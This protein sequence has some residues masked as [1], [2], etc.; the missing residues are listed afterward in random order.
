MIRPQM[1]SGGID[2]PSPE[3]DRKQREAFDALPLVEQFAEACGRR[4][5]QGEKIRRLL[6]LR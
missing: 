2:C 1:L 5:Q 4:A 3:D 6:V